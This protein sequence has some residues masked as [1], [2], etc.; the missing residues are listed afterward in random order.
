MAMPDGPQP[1]QINEPADLAKQLDRLRIRAAAGTGKVRLSVRDIAK[2]TAIPRSTLAGYLSGATPVPADLL[3]RIVRALGATPQEASRWE[4]AAHRL[5]ERH[6]R[7]SLPADRPVA[8]ARGR[9]RRVALIAAAVSAAV[10]VTTVTVVVIRRG[11]V[12][13]TVTRVDSWVTVTPDERGVARI[14]YCEPATPCRF[15][16]VPQVLVTGRAP[17]GGNVIPAAL[18]ANGE[19]L[20]EF[21]LRALDQRGRPI[22]D[23]IEVWYQ[24]A[25]SGSGPSEETGVA[26]T[27]TDVNGFATIAYSRTGRGVPIT[28]VAS[29]VR[30][31]NGPAIPGSVVVT[32]RTAEVFRIL[33]LSHTGTP[34]TGTSVTVAYFA[35]WNAGPGGSGQASRNAT[36]TVTTDAAGFAAVNF[37]QPMPA[38][39]DGIQAAA[40]APAATSIASTVL[41]HSATENGFLL[42]VLDQNGRGLSAT[43]VTVSYHA[44]SGSRR[45][46]G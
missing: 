1:D 20:V 40:V 34:V 19:T 32:E 30:P 7:R 24:A 18:V 10:A 28:V 21:T 35:G 23:P 26:T 29:G 38:E 43:A 37:A 22:N 36:T 3:V 12:P 31:S 4:R 33:V 15:A 5:A 41:P 13:V 6:D 27:T 17:P 8:S 14:R 44:V 42:R 45:T 25:V 16:A 11:S 46:A 9:G 2:A 39:P